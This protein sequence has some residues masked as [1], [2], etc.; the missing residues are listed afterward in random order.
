[1]DHDLFYLDLPPKRK[2]NQ[3]SSHYICTMMKIPQFWTYS[4]E[5]IWTS[6]QH[7]SNWG[8]SIL[9]RLIVNL[10]EGTQQNLSIELQESAADQLNEHRLLVRNCQLTI[11]RCNTPQHSGRNIV[12]P[13]L[14][15]K[16][17]NQTHYVL[18]WWPINSNWTRKHKRLMVLQTI[19]FL[20]TTLYK[21][22]IT[23]SANQQIPVI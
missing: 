13:Q 18:K 21:T 17:K 20:K 4:L 16:K 15:Q 6:Q 1:M 8:P 5:A 9:R 3:Q 19:T 10:A 22:R 11:N 2:T 14:K 23:D 7:L 12:Y